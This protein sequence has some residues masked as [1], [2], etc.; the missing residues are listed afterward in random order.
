[1]KIVVNL[2]ISALALAVSQGVYGQQSQAQDMQEKDIE[3]VEVK[4][5]A[6]LIGNL[7]PGDNQLK[8]IFGA[9]MSAAETP[10]SVTSLSSEALETFNIDDLHDIVKAAPNAYASSGFGT[11]SLPSIRGQLGELFQDGIRRQA[12]NN[13][14]GLPLSFNGVEQVDVVKGPSPVLFGSTQRNG[15]FVNLQTKVASTDETRGKATVRAGRWDQYSA[16]L[17][18]S[19]AIDEGVSGI[20]VSAEY[21]DHGSFYIM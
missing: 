9:G 17:D 10:R 3:V 14:F 12:G 13:G 1:M 21:L 20:R 15:G 16:Q 5:N 11:P 19:T 7:N 6:S 4:G 8:G 18:V 2:A